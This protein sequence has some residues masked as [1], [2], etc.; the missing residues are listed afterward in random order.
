MNRLFRSKYLNLINLGLF[1]LVSLSF[2]YFTYNA[3]FYVPG[4]PLLPDMSWVFFF[5]A[6]V[7]LVGLEA[8]MVYLLVPDFSKRTWT[9]LL[10]THLPWALG[11]AFSIFL[12]LNLPDPHNFIFRKLQ[13]L[14][15]VMWTAHLFLF[16][17]WLLT[18]LGKK[19]GNYSGKF[20]WVALYFFL[21]MT[22]WTTQCDLSGDEPHYLLMG[23]SLLHDGDLD[24]ANNYQNQDYL[25]FYHRGVLSPQGLDHFVDGKIFSY[26]PLGPVLLILPG[27]A[28]LG[29]MGAS[30]TMAVLAALALFLTLR[31]MEETGA[32]GWPLQAVAWIS[33][34]SSPVLLFAGLIYPEVPT[35]LLM[36]LALMLFLRKRW[37]LLGLSLGAMLWMH[38][39]NVL[40][41][42][43]LLL[44]LPMETGKLGKD[45]WKALGRGFVG[46]LVP[47][48]LLA[49]YFLKVYGVFT[50]LGA[51]HEPFASLFP[52]S[53]FFI[54]F[55]GLVL[56]QECGLWF[57]FPVFALFVAGGILLWKS[58]NP[59]RKLVLGTFAF[60][61]LFMCFYE[62]LGLT[63][64][65]RYIVGVTP[66]LMIMLY[67]VLKKIQKRE[68][69]LKLTGF[70]FGI[71]VA[72]NWILAAV[73]WM[74]YN[75]LE[76]ENWILK[77]LGDRLHLP[78]T[79]WE[80]AFHAS[81]IEIKSYLLGAFWVAVILALTAWFLKTK[82]QRKGN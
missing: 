36:A 10:L 49:F 82:V 30:L 40:L 19:A 1:L 25:H 51:H 43:P 35:A 21:G 15:G 16:S 63:P 57:H 59:L 13:I 38:N 42:I 66:L 39:R 46:F 22:L 73:P 44:L 78:L 79:Q 34:F 81:P 23:Y 80:P 72:V 56:D 5:L 37:G 68:G 50:P 64:A 53:R 71:G 6:F 12:N 74:R 28:I 60:F 7:L 2:F 8:L 24:L 18:R 32:K 75:K 29:R 61:Y 54:G 52:L 47:V 3:Y 27:F 14:F 20:L 62:N 45:R 33:F 17:G 48:V 58:K 70:L 4:L 26:H 76:G 65:A 77:I 41:V 69:W 9:P 11:W 67:P 31:V 55:F